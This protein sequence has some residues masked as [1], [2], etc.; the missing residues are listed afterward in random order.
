MGEGEAIVKV[1][2][3]IDY[4]IENGEPVKLSAEYEE[5]PASEVARFFVQKFGSPA[6]FGEGETN[7]I[8]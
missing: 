3:T 6:I 5:I 7:D 4:Q 1:P 8:R 2:M